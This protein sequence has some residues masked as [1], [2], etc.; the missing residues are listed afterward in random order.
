MQVTEKN[1]KIADKIMEILESE[2]CTVEESQEILSSVSTEIR[3]S[4]T[5][6]IREKFV[7]RFKDVL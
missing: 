3:R 5:V 4:S 1:C 2:K 6:Q 7:Q